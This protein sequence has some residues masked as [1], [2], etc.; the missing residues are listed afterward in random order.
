MWAGYVGLFSIIF[1]ETGLLV[2]FFFPGDSLLV[3]AGLFA[4]TGDMNIFF[5]N[6]LLIP[7][8]ILGNS[9]GYWIGYK[10]GP[11]LFKREQSL[12]FRKDYL[13]KTKEFYDRHGGSTIIITRFMPFFRT[14][15]PIVAGIGQMKYT[16]FLNYNIVSAFFWVLSMTLIGFFLGRS[17]PNIDK[18]IEK[19]IVVIVFLSLLPAIIKY[20]KHKLTKKVA[21]EE[22]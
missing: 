20:I 11:R 12:L 21:A 3:T 15:A 4:S 17:I 9:A 1:A 7:A 14:F 13:I 22:T 5:L 16:K 8:A 19:V 18:H 2:G 10:S 6:L